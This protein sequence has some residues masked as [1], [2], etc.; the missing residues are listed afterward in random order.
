MELNRNLTNDQL[1]ADA[2]IKASLDAGKIVIIDK[3][4]TAN[5]EYTNLYFIGKVE[6]LASSNTGVSSLAAQLLGW[7]NSDIYMRSIQNANT[8][9]ANQLPIG[10]ALPGT[11]RVVD[12]TEKAFDNQTSRIDRDGNHLLHNGQ[13]IYRNTEICTIEELA[14]KGHYTLEVTEKV[15]SRSQ[16]PVNQQ[17]PV[18]AEVEQA[19]GNT[20]G[21][22]TQ[23]TDNVGGTPS[24]SV[25]NLLGGQA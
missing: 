8:E 19:S 21:N 17:Q 25:N 14:E 10:S 15:P 12:S 4:P 11:I 3:V 9:V 2:N 23:Q 20:V 13:P 1:L 18:G 22:V 5:P 6:G 7:N 16:Q 24:S